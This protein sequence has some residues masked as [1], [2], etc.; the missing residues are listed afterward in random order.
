MTDG[1]DPEHRRT[2]RFRGIDNLIPLELVQ[3]L[4]NQDTP[5]ND[6]TLIH[7]LCDSYVTLLMKQEK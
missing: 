7:W 4:R 3:A 2:Y 5:V 6:V 1:S